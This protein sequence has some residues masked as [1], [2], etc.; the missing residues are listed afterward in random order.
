M[1]DLTPQVDIS[2]TKT[3]GVTSVAAGSPTTYTMIVSNAG[4]SSATGVRC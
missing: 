1:I 4:P 3:D 2:V